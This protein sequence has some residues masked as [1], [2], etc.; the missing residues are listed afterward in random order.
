MSKHKNNDFIP[1]I[2]IYGDHFMIPSYQRGYRW[3]RSQVEDLLNDFKDFASNR[4]PEDYYCLQPLVVADDTHN[5]VFRVID[6]QQR[7]TTIWMLLHCIDSKKSSGFQNDLNKKIDS[8]EMF[9][10]KY[11]RE[12]LLEEI[13]DLDFEKFSRFTDVE[14]KKC[15]IDSSSYQKWNNYLA[16]QWEVFRGLGKSISVESF[17]LFAAWLFINNWLIDNDGAISKDLFGSI[18]IIWHEVGIGR[19]EEETFLNLNGGKIPLTNAEL[20]KALFLNSYGENEGGNNL[21]QDQIAEEFDAIERELRKDDFWYF[22]NGRGAKP[23]SC[24]GLLFTLIQDLDNDQSHKHQEFR[25]YFYFRNK[26]DSLHSA[27]LVWEKVRDCFHTLQGWY[28]TPEIYNLVG[29]LRAKNRSIKEIYETYLSCQSV[30]QFI[31]YLKYRCLETIGWYDKELTKERNANFL[32]YLH[33]NFRFD[34]NKDR[35]WNLLLLINVVT[36][37]M[38]K[39]QVKDHK[40]DITKFSFSDFHNCEWNIEHISPQNAKVTEGMVIPG[41]TNLPPVGEKLHTI[42]DERIKRKIDPYIALMGETIMDLSN[43]TFLSEHINKSIGNKPY[44]EKRECVIRKQSEGFYLP[45]S[46]LMVF[47]KG[48]NSRDEQLQETNEGKTGFWSDVDRN[49]YLNKIKEI[50]TDK[51]LED[52][53]KFLKD[54][55]L[56]RKEEFSPI[57]N[58]LTSSVEKLEDTH[59]T[60]ALQRLTYSQ[61]IARDNYIIIPKIQRDYAQG[62]SMEVDIRAARIRKKLLKDIFYMGEQG[63]DFQIVFGSEEIRS[64]ISS[65]N[66]RPKVFIPIDGQQRLTTLFLLSL[67]R[68]KS[69]RKQDIPVAFLYETRRAA[70]DFCAAIV[71]NDWI[72]FPNN[73]PKKVI[74][75]ST[76]FKQYWLQDPTVDAMLRMLDGIHKMEE[77]SGH[78]PDIDKIHFSY[79]N[80]G[81]ASRSDEIYLKMNTRGK[82]LTQFENLKATIEK[83]FGYTEFEEKELWATWKKKIDS[84][85]IDGFWNVDH[86]TIVPDSR[87]LRFIANALFIRLC[88]E[89]VFKELNSLDDRPDIQDETQKDEAARINALIECASAIWKVD[90][91]I[92]DD[93]YVA[94]EPFIK[95]IE[96]LGVGKS[97]NYLSALLNAFVSN[98]NFRP[99]WENNNSEILD[100][101]FSQRAALYGASIFIQSN[102]SDDLDY[103]NQFYE[104][105][106]VVWNI[107]EH[108]SDNF[109]NFI[110]T[111]RLFDKIYELGGVENVTETLCLE[112]TNKFSDTE[113]FKEEILKAS[114]AKD[115]QLY[116]LVK[117]AEKHAFFHGSIRFLFDT[118]PDEGIW[119]AFETKVKNLSNLIPTIEGERQTVEKIIPYLSDQEIKDVFQRWY[120]NNKDG[121][122][123]NILLYGNIRNKLHKFFKQE[124]VS[125]PLSLLQEQLINLAPH[126]RDFYIIDKWNGANGC[127]PCVFTNY[128]RQSG[129]YATQSFPL[130][131]PMFVNIQNIL[132]DKPFTPEISNAFKDDKYLF[133]LE[134]NFRY[135]KIRFK[136][137]NE[138]HTIRLV[139]SDGSHIDKDVENSTY[140]VID[141]KESRETLQAKLDRLVDYSENLRRYKLKRIFEMMSSLEKNSETKPVYTGFHEDKKTDEIIQADEILSFKWSSVEILRN[142]YAITCTIDRDH[143]VEVGLRILPG[144]FAKTK[145]IHQRIDSSIS[146]NAKNHFWHY[147]F[148]QF[149]LDVEIIEREINLLWQQFN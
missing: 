89:D 7:L 23:T 35:V 124:S 28:N 108:D 149:Q 112:E 146:Y 29:F 68:D 32:D 84:I 85:W 73:S 81:L 116:S 45:P 31:K 121:N 38:Q 71:K 123:L 147:V 144:E 61:L 51:Y 54:A 58:Y 1:V 128:T 63:L 70:T 40:R 52:A 21:K 99:Y 100:Q 82:E 141:S 140:I 98:L 127:Y 76:W 78:F 9:E 83:K 22:L 30:D 56:K 34:K 74:L 10:L 95:T 136:Y 87:I 2:D 88:R 55:S 19:E 91:L 120:T 86:P 122:L 104:W 94:I 50:L 113:Q 139:G 6:G 24:I 126:H 69:H 67:Y 36:L 59:D 109:K 13:A 137:Y 132:R 41:M 80:I 26:I 79:F 39:P 18:R 105:M 93:K 138:N 46:S 114:I 129:A 65:N 125:I 47:T 17:H 92:K 42:D 48:Y 66:P 60:V 97:L 53:E 119:N 130:D 142:D 135:R 5:K 14:L 148:A 118:M 4:T 57:F 16:K 143:N 20:I 43:L 33:H 12:S 44:D 77:T 25:N 62:R 64:E 115:H 49:A 15:N 37:N 131:D 106:R 103:K 96:L 107:A 8:T 72:G 110:R 27:T 11:E 90:K 3:T 75:N 133:G 117:K 134:I 102:L 101:N 111:C 145:K